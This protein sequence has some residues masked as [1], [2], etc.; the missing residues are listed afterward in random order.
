MWEVYLNMQKR[1]DG[2]I[3]CDLHKTDHK[4]YFTEEEALSAIRLLPEDIQKHRHV[5]KVFVGLPSDF[6]FEA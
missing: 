3:Y 4:I 2:K 1:S 6:G 5:V